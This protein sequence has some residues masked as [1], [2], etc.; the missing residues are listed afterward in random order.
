MPL[1]LVPESV[2]GFEGWKTIHASL[3]ALAAALGVISCSA[4]TVSDM[5]SR[6]GF[7]VGPSFED[8]ASGR[9]ARGRAVHHG[10]ASLLR[11][12][13][14]VLMD[15]A[16]SATTARNYHACAQKFL[17]WCLWTARGCKGS[18]ELDAVLAAFFAHIFLDG[19]DGA[20]GRMTMGRAE[21]VP[22]QTRLPLPRVATFASAGALLAQGRIA[23]ATF[24]RLAFD[25]N[26]RPSEAYRLAAASLIAPRVG[27][28]EGYQHWATLANEASLRSFPP[29]QA[30]R[31]FEN[32]LV[33]LQ[34]DG[35]QAPLR[36]LRLLRH[37]GASDDLLAAFLDFGGKV[38]KDFLSSM[39]AKARA[40]PALTDQW[41]FARSGCG[42]GLD[43]ALPSCRFMSFCARVRRIVFGELA[44]PAGLKLRP[45]TLLGAVMATLVIL[46][47]GAARLRRLDSLLE[48]TT[49]AEADRRA[50]RVASALAA[51]AIRLI[52]ECIFHGE[53]LRPDAA[54]PSSASAPPPPPPPP[55]GGGSAGERPRPGTAYTLQDN[56]AR[57]DLIALRSQLRQLEAQAIAARRESDTMRSE[58]CEMQSKER[59][60][61]TVGQHQQMEYIRNVF[62]KFVETAPT[63]T[64][65]HEMLI[66]VLM[67]FFKFEPE[68]TKAIQTRRSQSTGGFFGRWSG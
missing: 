57:Q 33:Q 21:L 60:Q 55:P 58:L 25:T 5:P 59:L 43:N 65:E 48:G 9:A 61:E 8:F 67:T 30:R 40:A 44:N 52:S 10:P 13:L 66:P 11:G 50:I 63:G 34:L 27:S 53:Q 1:I 36:S 64:K 14:S 51:A 23:E 31:A 18:T 37:W 19:Y 16:V 47:V 62:R 54:Q 28:T 56:M 45:P 39:E 2:Y 68:A 22:P 24:V 49:G 3:H 42:D 7:F 26:L 29:D 12:S 15:S 6:Q 17:S 35:E 46:R 38:E 41:A 20:T 4:K 32:F